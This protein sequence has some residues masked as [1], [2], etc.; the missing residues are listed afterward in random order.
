[1][2]DRHDSNRG[3]A[4]SPQTSQSEEQATRRDRD[5]LKNDRV[6]FNTREPVEHPVLRSRTRVTKSYSLTTVVWNPCVQKARTLSA[7]WDDK[8]TQMIGIETSNGAAISFPRAR[9]AQRGTTTR[10]RRGETRQLRL[11]AAAVSR[12]AVA[13]RLPAGRWHRE[14]IDTAACPCS[15]T[16][17]ELRIDCAP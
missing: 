10:G 12:L 3:T 16:L 11:E 13:S 14:P 7:L 4:H 8:W 9:Q 17:N 2:V 6:Y 5:R 1:M 15:L